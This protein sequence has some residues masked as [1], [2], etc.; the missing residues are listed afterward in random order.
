MR[1]TKD[2]T[3]VRMR[4]VLCNKGD[5]KG[6]DVRARLVACEVA[7]D[8][9]SAFYASTTPL[10]SKKALFS[11]H[12]AQRK[13][14]GKPLALSFIDN[15]NTYF[16]GVPQG[17]I[18]MSPPR[19]IGLGKMITQQTKCVHGKRNAGIIWEKTYRQCL[20]DLGFISGK[21][22]PC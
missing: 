3:C 20:E 22:G 1:A 19:E 12:A 18:F 17:N 16:N 9:V 15:K 4:W 14:G 7:K 10:E 5:L 11:R 21:A 13:Q 2:S 8:N 6:P